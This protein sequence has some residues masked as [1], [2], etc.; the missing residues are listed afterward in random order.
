MLNQV[1]RFVSFFKKVFKLRSNRF[2]KPKELYQKNKV[3]L[4]GNQVETVV[5]NILEITGLTVA[6]C[7][8]ALGMLVLL[9]ILFHI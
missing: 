8:F 9:R 2:A 3:H 1:S 6:G 5:Y 7:I 4:I